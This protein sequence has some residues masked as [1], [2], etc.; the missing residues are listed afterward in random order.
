LF[1]AQFDLLNLNANSFYKNMWQSLNEIY[2]DSLMEESAYSLLEFA[3][4]RKLRPPSEKLPFN[5]AALT[6]T[7]ETREEKDHSN[8]YFMS[9][10]VVHRNKNQKIAFKVLKECR[11]PD[12]KCHSTLL[13][14]ANITPYNRESGDGMIIEDWR[15]ENFAN[16][17]N[18]GAYR[19][20]LSEKGSAETYEI[21][22]IV[23]PESK[24][25]QWFFN[26]QP[27]PNHI[28]PEGKVKVSFNKINFEG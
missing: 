7:F 3:N 23:V 6:V 16:A 21:D 11:A 12:F 13:N 18:S 17:F 8:Q 20:S 5:L 9:V 25:N 4:M 24:S 28:W 15:S 1:R 10:Q 19:I 14:S 26:T 27:V 22:F 2:G